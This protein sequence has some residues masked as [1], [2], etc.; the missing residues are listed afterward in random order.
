MRHATALWAIA[1]LMGAMGCASTQ[2]SQQLV[3]ARRTYQRAAEGPAARLTPAALY[4]AR[5]ALMEA[6]DAQRDHP[7]S[8]RA[9]SLAYIADRKAAEAMALADQGQALHQVALARQQENQ[10][11]E[12][13]LHQRE[14]DLRTEQAARAQAEQTA[15][16]AVQSLSQLAKVRLEPQRMVITLTGQVLFPFGKA[17]LLP[18]ARTRLDQVATAL[19]TQP[20]DTTIVVNGYT[21]SIGDPAKNQELSR[22]RAEAVRDYLV[23]QG[24]APD[25]I[26]AFGY[27]AENPIANNTTPEGRADNRRVEI[28]LKNEGEGCK[29]SAR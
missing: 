9:R 23:A 10:V 29:V 5:A 6:E 11:L 28:V 26:Q 7:D 8:L 15:Q 17:A 18:S 14:R 1:F 25:R 4:E 27:G 20:R 3:D 19:K 13:Q 21:D 2:P 12:R 22:Q 24:V 16:E